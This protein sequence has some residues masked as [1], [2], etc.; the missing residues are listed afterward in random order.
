MLKNFY[1]LIQNTWPIP[2]PDCSYELNLF[3]Y[4]IQIDLPADLLENLSPLFQ[5]KRRK[6]IQ[7]KGIKLVENDHTLDENINDYQNSSSIMTNESIEDSRRSTLKA[8]NT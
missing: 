2:V 6:Q 5:L 8:Y 7:Q 3:G 4:L 1:E